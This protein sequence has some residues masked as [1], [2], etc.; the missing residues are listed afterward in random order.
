L[1]RPGTV[2]ENL[3]HPELSNC[4]ATV[5]I[6]LMLDG[7]LLLM[8]EDIEEEMISQLIGD[9][10]RDPSALYAACKQI[11][12][13]PE[14][15]GNFP[16]MAQRLLTFYAYHEPQ[17]FY[18]PISTYDDL[19]TASLMNGKLA[20][21]GVPEKYYNGLSVGFSVFK[22]GYT[23]PLGKLPLPKADEVSRGEH[24][25]GL[26]GWDDDGE[27]LRFANSWGRSWG[28]NGYGGLTRLYLEQHMT[29]AW[30][31]RYVAVGLTRMTHQRLAGVTN[32]QEFAQ[33]WMS[34]NHLRRVPW[35]HMGSDHQLIL[36]ETLSISGAPVEIIE[37][38][39]DL[40]LR[41]GW[42]HLHHVPIVQPRISI[43]KELYVWPIFRR[44]GYATKL[45][46]CARARA[47]AWKSTRMQILFHEADAMPRVRSA[48]QSFT[49]QSAYSL[50]WGRQTRPTIDAIAEKLL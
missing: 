36:Y 2:L 4:Q 49:E 37:I 22:S 26:A 5:E 6:K 29:E 23:A 17:I 47:V 33:I 31:R 19:L 21:G 38:R 25:V 40:G 24:I 9:I 8:R 14:A 50:S 34:K 41:V 28:D 1:I 18:E 12:G 35:Q 32:N 3:F 13:Y 45:E 30:L 16:I 10:P 42:A 39:N 7:G 44:Q 27:T 15:E 43:L 48:G 20:E 46:S 11:D